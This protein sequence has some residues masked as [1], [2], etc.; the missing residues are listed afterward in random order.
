LP[1]AVAK[2]FTAD[3]LDALGAIKRRPAHPGDHLAEPVRQRHIMF[4]ESPVKGNAIR[5]LRA[6]WW[7]YIE[8]ADGVGLLD[9]DLRQRLTSQDDDDF[10]GALAECQT[11]W[12]FNCRLGTGLRRHAGSGGDFDDGATMRVEVKAPYVPVQSDVIHGDD[13]DVLAKC[14]KKAG[15]QFDESTTNLVVICPL[16]RTP[17]WMQRDQIVKACI[18]EW[19]ISVPVS[20]DGSE[21]GDAKPIFLQNGKLAKM[22]PKGGAFGPDHRRVSAVATIEEKVCVKPEGWTIQHIAYVVHNPFAAVR[23]PES[24]FD[25]HPQLVLRDTSM[26]WTDMR[27][28]A[29]AEP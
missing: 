15:E 6:A 17:V 28:A 5:A 16:L 4:S 9:N 24:I 3:V 14:I 20:L 19:A 23:A 27:S 11:S 26:S 7:M 18:G 25:D 12:F 22:F 13:S 8:H 1:D 29:S 21:P 2:V 10:R